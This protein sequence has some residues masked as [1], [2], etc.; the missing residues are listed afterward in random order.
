M[1]QEFPS[2]L[3]NYRTANLNF[4][5]AGLE[6]QLENGRHLNPACHLKKLS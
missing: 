2:Q 3:Y 6:K 1:N 5:S 4:D